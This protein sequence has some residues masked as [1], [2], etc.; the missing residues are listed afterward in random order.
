MGTGFASPALAGFALIEEQ[1]K[2]TR[3]RI[4]TSHIVA[5]SLHRFTWTRTWRPVQLAASERL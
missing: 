3:T 1:E 2:I 5:I 4:T